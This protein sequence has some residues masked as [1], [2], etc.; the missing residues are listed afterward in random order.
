MR[1]LSY[2]NLRIPS[3]KKEVEYTKDMIK[4]HKDLW[5]RH[6]C[7]CLMGGTTEQIKV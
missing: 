4:N 1:P 6:E 2:H 3:L 5:V 7:S